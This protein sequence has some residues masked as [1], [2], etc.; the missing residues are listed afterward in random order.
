LAA[1]TGHSVTIF[2]RTLVLKKLVSGFF[3][4]GSLF[5][6]KTI[7]RDTEISKRIWNFADSII[8]GQY[9]TLH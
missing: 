6:H 9:G 8:R 7:L 2:S 4:F 3:R 1:S 5:A